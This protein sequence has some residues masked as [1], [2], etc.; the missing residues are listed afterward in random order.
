MERLKPW[1]DART[2]ALFLKPCTPKHLNE[3]LGRY[4]TRKS[5]NR[6]GSGHARSGGW[7][8][9]RHDLERVRAI[10]DALGCAPLRAAQYF[11]VMHAFQD[12]K[13]LEWLLERELT[14]PED[15]NQMDIESV[16]KRLKR[17]RFQ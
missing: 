8:Y 15:Q 5:G 1:S 4:V 13:I 10:M 7:W 12:R 6:F 14:V 16:I 3:E 2:A 17:R 9:A 11:H